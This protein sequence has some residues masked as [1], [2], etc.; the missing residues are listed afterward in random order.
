MDRRNF[1]KALMAG[2][3]LG[4]S[5][6]AVQAAS[7]LFT[8]GAMQPVMIVGQS[9]LPQASELIA[10]LEQ[11]LSAAGLP[12][13]KATATGNELLTFS[14]VAAFLDRRPGSYLLGVMDDSAA[15]IFQELAAARG[16]GCLVSTHHRFVDQKVRH[17]CTSAGL[18]VS[19]AWSDSLPA[20]AHRIGRLYADLVGGPGL[21]P[22]QVAQ[23]SRVGSIV[24]APASL[25]S[26][27]IRT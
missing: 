22:D 23:F 17:C 8:P 25:V 6:Q 5:S 19:V 10:G 13:E 2:G 14:P 11:V 26:F 15:M 16:A 4:A 21:M 24:A 9:G 18:E 12:H 1:V 7:Q 20:H 3:V 27:L